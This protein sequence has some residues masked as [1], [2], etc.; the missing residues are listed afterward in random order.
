VNPNFVIV[1]ST[2]GSVMDALLAVPFFRRAISSV[3]AD[4][5]CPAVAK[6]ARHGVPAVVLPEKNKAVFCA[7]LLE[8]LK[9]QRA[10]YVLSF[11]SKLFVGEL[12]D[13]F[14]DRIINLH[15]AILPAFKGLDG[16]GDA[17]A[18]GVRYVGT[19]IHFIDEHM[20]EG[21]IIL[22]T[23]WPHDP[24]ANLRHLR[25]RLFEQQCRSLLQTVKWLS[26]GRVEI[27]G[28]QVVIRDAV[29][30]DLEFSPNLDFADAIQ[31]RV[32]FPESLDG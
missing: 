31:F 13:V 14:R 27:V 9:V 8:Y 4:R 2:A 3:V 10:E 17:V 29:Y 25:H 19:T 6:A 32:P 28:N 18:Y 20:D 11:Y 5:D 23:V 16:F 22:Q 21:K 30:T 24:R 26:D 7:R 1:T 15:P 12:L